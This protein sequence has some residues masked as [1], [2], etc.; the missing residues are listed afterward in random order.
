MQWKPLQP[1]CAPAPDDPALTCLVD[2][3]PAGYGARRADCL[4]VGLLVPVR[5]AA[6]IWGPSARACAQLAAEELN[7]QGGI[8][9]RELRLQV[10]NAVDECRDIPDLLGGLVR[11]GE[12]DAVVGMHTSAVRSRVRA[13]TGGRIPF[14]YTPLYEGGE[15]APGVYA[16]GETPDQQL[17]PA[18]AAMYRQYRARRWVF[19]GNDC[20]WPRASHGLASGAL[21]ALGGE[22]LADRYVEH[23]CASYRQVLQEIEMLRPDAVLLSL[24]GQDAVRFNREFGASGLQRRVRR[25]SCAIEENGLLAIGAANTEGLFAAAGYFAALPN[26]ANMAF[27][28]RYHGRFGE[29]APVLNALGQSVYDGVH[30]LAALAAAPQRARR[31]APLVF[32]SVRGLSWRGNARVQQPVFL[33][34]ANGHFF[35]VV[36]QL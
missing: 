3:P 31:T 5:G 7:R 36:R 11:E 2:A 8:R 22:V 12:L 13:A 24:I 19:V 29:R 14:V 6:G 17:L 10:F 4:N 33:A 35:N 23:G 20:V 21:R 27:K 34:E 28:E 32:R 18:L 15:C 9:G 30:F 16:I 1:S 26:E 25:L